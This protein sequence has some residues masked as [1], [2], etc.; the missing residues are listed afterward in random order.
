M[1]KLK[2]L[3]LLFV[4]CGL[5]SGCAA[6]KDGGQYAMTAGQA[7]AVLGELTDSYADIGALV[8]QGNFAADELGRLEVMD[9]QLRAIIGTVAAVEQGELLTAGE[10]FALFDSARV[11]Y[12]QAEAIIAPHLQ[13]L[14]PATQVR[15]SRYDQQARQ[16]ADKVGWLR[17]HDQ[18][19]SR[20]MMQMLNVILGIGKVVVPLLV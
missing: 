14:P 6:L 8:R 12:L 4:F 17:E 16:L 10:F 15:L 11:F 5:V 1:Q 19:D 18:V 9:L 13:T 3:I 2:G 7:G 20:S